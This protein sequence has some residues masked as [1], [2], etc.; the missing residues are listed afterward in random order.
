MYGGLRFVFDVS[1]YAA[2]TTCAPFGAFETVPIKGSDGDDTGLAVSMT[3]AGTRNSPGFLWDT[4][5][6]LPCIRNMVCGGCVV[7]GVEATRFCGIPTLLSSWLPVF[8]A[9]LGGRGGGNID[10]TPF[11]PLG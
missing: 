11:R 2:V 9:G 1:G 8:T 5:L 6:D 4:V 10:I 7:V 3:E